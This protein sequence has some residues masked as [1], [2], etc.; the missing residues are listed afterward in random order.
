MKVTFRHRDRVGVSSIIG[1]RGRAGGRGGGV[2]GRGRPTLKPKRTPSGLFSSKAFP[3]AGSGTHLS[4]PK[5]TKSETDG[6]IN[7]NVGWS[8]KDTKYVKKHQT[9]KKNTVRGPPLWDQKTE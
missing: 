6:M 4:S 8:T 3:E 1:G 9:R 5:D 2:G 7:T